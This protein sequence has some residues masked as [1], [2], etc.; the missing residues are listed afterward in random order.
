MNR[1]ALGPIACFIMVS[2]LISNMSNALLAEDVETQIR[3]I[4]KVQKEGSGHAAA[5][6]VL[7]RL[8]QQPSTSLIP[9][10]RGIDGANPLA[11][12]WLRGAFEAI[13][14]RNLKEGAL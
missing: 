12:N 4:L 2:F 13:A 11:A 6:P 1:M 8:A 5:V 10:L 14:D 7:R 3:T 9:L